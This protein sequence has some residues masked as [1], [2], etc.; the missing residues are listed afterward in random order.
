MLEAIFSAN[1]KT[2]HRCVVKNICMP[3]KYIRQKFLDYQEKNNLRISPSMVFFK[4]LDIRF[5][6]IM[7][8]Q[9]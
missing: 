2:S 7:A 3:L 9:E 5:T 1:L 4:L 6:Q 8:K